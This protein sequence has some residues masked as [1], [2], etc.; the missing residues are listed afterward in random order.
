M[1]GGRKAR[2][3]RKYR[4]RKKESKDGGRDKTM[5]GTKAREERECDMR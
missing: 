5:G 4:R 3:E 1:V 2:V